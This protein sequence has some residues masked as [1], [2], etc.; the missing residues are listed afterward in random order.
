MDATEPAKVQVINHQRRLGIDQ[1]AV[2]RFCVD[3]LQTLK[4]SNRMLSVVFVG[5]RR[6]KTL[7][8][9][10][11]DR[12]YATD[13]LSFSYGEA[14]MEGSDFLGE[15]IICPEVAVQNALRYRTNPQ[16]ELW[17][18]LIHGLL[19]LLGYDHEADRGIMNRFQARLLGRKD[20][21]RTKMLVDIKTHR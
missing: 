20:F 1:N 2:A 3:L 15:I 5:R 19:H 14:K 9:R 17:K 4:Q 8:R 6:M 12:D 21:S 11:L 10:Y 16:R 7:N 13:V 18:L